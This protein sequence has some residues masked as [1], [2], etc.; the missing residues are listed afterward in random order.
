MHIKVIEFQEKTDCKTIGFVKVLYHEIFLFLRIRRHQNKIYIEMPRVK[1]DETWVNCMR[2]SSC[3]INDFFLKEILRQLK[4][5]F[6]IDL[7]AK[8]S[9]EPKI[10]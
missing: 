10:K 8:E 2:W 9:V 4:E 5:D 7:A 1:I 3:R 6:N